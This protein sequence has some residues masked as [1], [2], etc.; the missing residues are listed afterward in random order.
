VGLRSVPN[1]DVV[2]LDND[3]ALGWV[4]R[5]VWG[6]RSFHELR[7]RRLTKIRIHLLGMRK[8]R[9]NRVRANMLLI[10]KSNG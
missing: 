7:S 2:P 8:I 4:I 10:G 1:R 6:N 5:R 9:K 3:T